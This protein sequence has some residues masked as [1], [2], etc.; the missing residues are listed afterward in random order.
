MGKTQTTDKEKELLTLLG[1]SPDTPLK[2]LVNRT[3][4]KRLSSIVRKIDQLKI[5]N[6][7]YGP[8]YTI[9]YGKLCKNPLCILYCT[10]EFNRDYETVGS[11]LKVIEPLRT[12]YPVL[13]PHKKLLNVQFLSSNNKE[14]A[15]L[16]QLLKDS[17][18]ITDFV[19]R[20]SR[21]KNVIKNPNFFGEVN[22]SLD[23]LLDPCDIPDTSFGQYST[24]WNERDVR[25]L[26]YVRTGYKNRKLIEI[27]RA[28]KDRVTPLTYEQVK[29]SF[30]KMVKN[31]LIEKKYLIFPFPYD[32]CTDFNMFIK[33]ENEKLTQRILYN[34]AKN[35][36]VTKEYVSCGTW[37]YVGFASHPLFLTGIMHKLDN[38]KEIVEK[39]LYQIRSTPDRGRVFYQY[40]EFKYFDFAEQTLYYPHR[41]YKE[42]IREKLENDT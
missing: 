24:E 21:H 33:T 15:A 16:L 9:D 20:V 29:Y 5:Q 40:P 23:N 31:K 28:E 12:V 2:H 17:T 13:S 34:A 37:G 11:Y 10:V 25:V 8:I 18:I 30:R 14:M 3:Q 38:I 35:A 36:R 6:M 1:S 42:K 39:E 19:I 26:P 4:Y 32:Q 27:V 22:P 7:I 41:L